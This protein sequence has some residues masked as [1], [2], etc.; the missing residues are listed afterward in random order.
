MSGLKEKVADV[1]QSFLL[2]EAEIAVD[3]VSEALCAVSEELP[4]LLEALQRG[5]ITADDLCYVLEQNKRLINIKSK[6]AEIL[7][8]IQLEE[9]QK[10]IKDALLDAAL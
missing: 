4:E 5:E 7:S 1:I 9:L 8:L 3:S 2:K 10:N 6:E